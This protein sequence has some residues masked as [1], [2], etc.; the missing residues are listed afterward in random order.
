MY[1]FWPKITIHV[2]FNIKMN[3]IL[4]IFKVNLVLQQAQ[5]ISSIISS[6]TPKWTSVSHLI[7]M[8]I[9]IYK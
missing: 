6:M 4:F 7:R 5:K 3:I 2:N 8:V 9:N 1:V